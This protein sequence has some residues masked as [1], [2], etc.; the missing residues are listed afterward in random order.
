M[1]DAI[2][3]LKG[4]IIK[5]LQDENQRLQVKCSKLEERVVATNSE[6]N[7]LNQ[8]GRRNNILLLQ[9]ILSLFS[10]ISWN[11]PLHQFY[12]ILMLR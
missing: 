3:N 1:R 2:I 12:Q 7:S 5:R 11:P 4:I 9:V 6:A 8:Y 10:T